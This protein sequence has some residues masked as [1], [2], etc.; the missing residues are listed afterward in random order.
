[1]PY[2]AVERI[3]EETIGLN[4]ESTGKLYIE[5]VVNAL[6]ERSGLHDVDSFIKLLR[7]SPEEIE[8]IFS[9]SSNPL[10]REFA[11][12]NAKLNCVPD[13]H[14]HSENRR[15]PVVETRF[16]TQTQAYEPLNEE[17]ARAVPERI[18]GAYAQFNN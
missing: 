13:T 12:L 8:R 4:T 18:R 11:Y 15:S 5:H 6:I 2:S 14:E 9:S 7:S 10:L 16:N 17:A 3:L 1:M